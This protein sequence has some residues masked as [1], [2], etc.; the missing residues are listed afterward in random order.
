MAAPR[1]A[2][3]VS[4]DGD[5]VG[6]SG[7]GN[8]TEQQPFLTTVPLPVPH[9]AGAGVAAQLRLNAKTSVVGFV[10]AELRCGGAPCLGGYTIERASRIKGNFISK[11]AGWGDPGLPGDFRLD[12]KPL[13]GEHVAVHLVLPD[14][15][16]YSVAFVCASGGESGTTTLE[17]DDGVQP[18]G[19][20]YT[21]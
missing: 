20:R 14:A 5:Y 13:E 4:V 7:F 9:C 15:E 17:S 3:F 16:L 6:L 12:L 2:R 18:P 1:V 21:S 10:A 8:Q 19:V 11:P